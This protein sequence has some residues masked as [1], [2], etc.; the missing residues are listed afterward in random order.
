MARI[1]LGFI[2]D[3]SLGIEELQISNF[4]DEK[5]E[6]ELCNCR[7]VL[8]LELHNGADWLYILSGVALEFHPNP[9]DA[10]ASL[11]LK[12]IIASTKTN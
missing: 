8:S 6:H 10:P 3:Y 1:F 12:R 7:N 11:E 4:Y 2:L 9:A 5:P